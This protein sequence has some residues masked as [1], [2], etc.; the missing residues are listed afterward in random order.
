MIGEQQEFYFR[1]NLLSHVTNRQIALF[2][3]TKLFKDSKR[4]TRFLK[5]Y[6]ERYSKMLMEFKLLL[7][8]LLR[9]L[10]RLAFVDFLL[11][12]VVRQLEVD[13]RNLS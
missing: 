6:C 11:A 4:L 2:C 3:F 8:P 10:Q 1:K 12:V 13:E 7:L 5:N 9:R